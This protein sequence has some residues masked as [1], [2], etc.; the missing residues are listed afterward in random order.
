MPPA[1]RRIGAHLRAARKEK[2][3]SISKLARSI[4]LSHTALSL[5]ER[6]ERPPSG[7]I[8]QGYARWLGLDLDKLCVIAGKIPEDL[9]KQLLQSHEII[10]KVRFVLDGGDA[11]AENRETSEQRTEDITL[12]EELL[13][14]GETLRD[15]Q[16][17]DLE[18]MLDGLH[19][20]SIVKLSTKQRGYIKRL[21]KRY[22]LDDE[23]GALFA[24]LPT[25]EREKQRSDAAKIVLPWEQKEP[26]KKRF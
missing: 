18:D 11:G 8:L 23:S 22:G 5:V 12:V 4:G 9:Q 16:Q 7:R 25:A 26:E 6:N 3:I 2:K 24:H 14:S 13:D 21:R 1:T 15:Q 20:V 17:E 19:S 10:K